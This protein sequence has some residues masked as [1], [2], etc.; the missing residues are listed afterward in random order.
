MNN[1][2]RSAITLSLTTAA[3]VFP[4]DS[5]QAEVHAKSK[6]LA[7]ME[8]RDL[9]EQAQMKGNSPFLHSDS[10]GSTYL[11]VEQLVPIGI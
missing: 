1:I 10:E 11:Y 2:I 3:L 8:A 5:S 6:D 7:I 4:L 9:P